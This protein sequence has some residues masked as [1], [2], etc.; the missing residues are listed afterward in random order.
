MALDYWRV[1]YISDPQQTCQLDRTKNAMTKTRT[2]HQPDT[3]C[4]RP[5]M[6]R[7]GIVLI[8]GAEQVTITFARAEV[9]W[10]IV[11]AVVL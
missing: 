10:R 11:L 9:H 6:F 5:D 7:I 2:G 4:R 8:G 3:N 1:M